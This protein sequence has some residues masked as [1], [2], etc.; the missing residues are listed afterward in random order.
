MSIL[1]HPDAQAIYRT[2]LD[3]PLD[4]APRLI[5][6]DW[7]D[8]QGESERAEYLRLA[9]AI[10]RAK[11]ADTT[12]PLRQRRDT[13]EAQ[14]QR[15]IW[16]DLPDIAMSV[17][18][19]NGPY[20]RGFCQAVRV[21]DV[22]TLQHYWP[23]LT[24]QAPVIEVQL[25]GKEN[26]APLAEMPEL[27][28]IHHLNVSFNHVGANDLAMRAILRSR[29]LHTLTGLGCG[30]TSVGE[31]TMTVLADCPATSTMRVLDLFINNLDA[32]LGK[33][34]QTRGWKALE[35]LN[36]HSI[37]ADVDDW[38]RLLH[39]PA[40][41]ALKRLRFGPPFGARG[42]QALAQSPVLSN[43]K[44]LAIVRNTDG[45]A[46]VRALVAGDCHSVRELE[47]LCPIEDNGAEALAHCASLHGLQALYIS[48]GRLSP[49]GLLTILRSPFLT[50]LR[51]LSIESNHIADDAV[52]E[53]L[54]QDRWRSL[55]LFSI[56]RDLPNVAPHLVTE[57]Q[58]C[59]G[60]RF[61]HYNRGLYR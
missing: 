59:F 26:L 18:W 25:T 21:P 28:R 24:A 55:E 29:Y 6:A 17:Y 41:H 35:E 49:S 38:E 12:L 42:V 58:R 36:L 5:L 9:C 45:A 40:C 54:S 33:L 4:D 11:F 60:Q 43:L 44:H 46:C 23:K 1:N 20:P 61:R 30:S 50:N 47:L 16:D 13:L 3:A 14:L 39:S 27:G 8:E 37:Q 34:A 32:G 2:I 15:H 10:D 56:D 19:E 53:I 7:L 22:T 51:Q 48:G 57:L 31:E 52:L